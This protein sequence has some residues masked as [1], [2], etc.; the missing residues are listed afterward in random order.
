MKVDN[1]LQKLANVDSAIKQIFLVVERLH[2][3]F[4]SP[5]LLVHNLCSRVSQVIFEGLQN[6]KKVHYLIELDLLNKKLH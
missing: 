3:T 1:I 6:T 4:N 5:K 2:P